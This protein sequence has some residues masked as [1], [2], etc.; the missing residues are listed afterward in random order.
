MTETIKKMMT[1]REDTLD[2]FP[3]KRSHLPYTSL[4]LFQNVLSFVPK[5]SITNHPIARYF[6]VHALD[7]SRF[8]R[9]FHIS[10]R[11]KY[12]TIVN[13]PE[14][15]DSIDVLP[16]YFTEEAR[17][18][19]LGDGESISPFEHWSQNKHLMQSLSARDQRETIY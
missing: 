12:Y 13:K 9:T 4:Q 11:G 19:D 15:Y 7:P 17:V 5:I 14:Y 1:Q 16:D 3:Y 6:K 10:Y 8:W 2:D 18:R